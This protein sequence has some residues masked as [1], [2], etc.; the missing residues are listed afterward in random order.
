MVF[1]QKSSVASKVS[2]LR[3]AVPLPVITTSGPICSARSVTKAE[4]GSGVITIG[5]HN[6]KEFIQLAP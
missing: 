1:V 5:S 4:L 6:A 2:P 3:L